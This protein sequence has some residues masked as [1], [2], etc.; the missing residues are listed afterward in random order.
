M[1]KKIIISNNTIKNIVL[2]KD[3]FP[4]FLCKILSSFHFDDKSAEF[5][6]CLFFVYTE[7]N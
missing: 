1:Y 2:E 7:S 4:L 6:L 5:F 3:L